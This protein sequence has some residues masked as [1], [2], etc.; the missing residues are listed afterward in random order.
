M[1]MA[2]FAVPRIL[3]WSADSEVLSSIVQSVSILVI[4][5]LAPCGYHVVQIRNHLM[6]WNPKAGHIS[7]LVD[8]PPRPRQ[9]VPGSRI[10][11][12]FHI[13]SQGFYNGKIPNDMELVFNPRLFNLLIIV[14]EPTYEVVCHMAIIWNCHLYLPIT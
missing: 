1:T 10:N 3:D 6:Q 12:E 9:L 7:I 8:V 11:E 14:S 2:F 13:I 5:D 4:Y